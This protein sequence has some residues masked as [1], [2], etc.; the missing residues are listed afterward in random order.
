MSQEGVDLLLRGYR[1]FVA[2]DLDAIEGM[3]D[4]EVEWTGADAEGAFDR[5]DVL[6]VLA[7]RVAEGY[8]V[9]VDRCIGVGDRVVV[10]MRFSRVEPDA[11]DERPLQSR[12]TYHMGRYAAVVT[13]RDGHVTRVEEHPHL[14]AALEAVGLEDEIA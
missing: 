13:M 6:G 12:R 1:A 10:S 14:A 11:T 7:E 4:P 8:H 3:L 2:G 5:A 9:T